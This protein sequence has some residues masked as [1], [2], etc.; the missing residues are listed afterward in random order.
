M[1]LRKVDL[2][3][4][5]VFDAI[6]RERN[7]TRVSEQLFVTQPTVSN[8]LS[9]LRQ[10]FDDQLFIRTPEGMI[11]TPVADNV[12]GDV[13]RALAL[14][15]KTVNITSRF[16]PATSEKHFRLGMN[17]LAQLLLLPRLER[18]I[19]KLAPQVG[20]SSYYQDRI[21][22]TEDLKSG[23]LDILLDTPPVNT[24][25]FEH[26]SLV[27]LCYVVAMRRDHP[28]SLSPLSI[29]D[30]LAADHIHVS[31]RKKGRGHADA[32][33]SEL[34]E[35]R[36]IRMRVQDYLVAAE[37]TR[38]SDLLW[39]AP[40]VL[41]RQT[42]L[43]LSE[44]PLEITPLIWHLYW[45]RNASDDPANQWLRGMIGETVAEIFPHPDTPGNH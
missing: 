19:Q 17:N 8:A 24:R 31:S 1:K 36:N 20:I 22:A 13:R 35:K 30:Y 37:V 14:L 34:G 23:G 38:Q 39:T 33:L 10:T 9:R 11:P 32:A 28:L 18:K 29:E 27:E 21:N 15:N 6:Y 12:I 42:D 4:F 16:D 2:N 25:D 7:I 43:H 5:V 3:L 40:L 44:P 45:N 26:R 41:A